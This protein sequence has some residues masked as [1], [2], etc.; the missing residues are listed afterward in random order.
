M[1]SFFELLWQSELWALAV[2]VGWVWGHGLV[3]S[4]SRRVVWGLDSFWGWGCSSWKGSLL[5][6]WWW[7]HSPGSSQILNPGARTVCTEEPW[8]PGVSRSSAGEAVLR[9]AG[10]AELW[11]SRTEGN[12][13]ETCLYFSLPLSPSPSPCFVFAEKPTLNPQANRHCIFRT[14]SETSKDLVLSANAPT[15]NS[16]L[17]SLCSPLVPAHRITNVYML[18]VVGTY[19]LI[20]GICYWTFSERIPTLPCGLL[21][22][23]FWGALLVKL[24]CW[25]WVHIL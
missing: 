14:R 13:I 17:I 16:C 23:P 3:P 6:E 5:P 11:T 15:P 2:A 21:H 24:A 4:D 18:G 9:P 1:W 12:S 25:Y 22:Y 20:F 7:W 10:L 8:L 19:H